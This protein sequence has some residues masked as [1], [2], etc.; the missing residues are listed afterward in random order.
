MKYRVWCPDRGQTIDD[1]KNVVESFASN[2]AQ[3]FAEIHADFW[4]DPFSEINVVV[5][6]ESGNEV[7]YTVEVR[8]VP[9]FHARRN[10]SP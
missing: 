1:A 4:G 3:E 10:G 2:A 8:A 6:D 5:R 7:G 9:E